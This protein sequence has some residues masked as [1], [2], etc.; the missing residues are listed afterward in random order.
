MHEADLSDGVAHRWGLADDWQLIMWLLAVPAFYYQLRM[1]LHS[2]NVVECAVY[3]KLRASM[4]SHVKFGNQLLAFPNVSPEL[5][6]Q[7]LQEF[8]VTLEG[9]V[10][11]LKLDVNSFVSDEGSR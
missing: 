10:T 2:A 6:M 1:S 11:T 5:R 7:A 4:L 9:I 8:R 3:E